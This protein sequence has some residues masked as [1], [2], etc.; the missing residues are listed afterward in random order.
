MDLNEL[1]Q[2]YK[3]DKISVR[4]LISRIK[5]SK[6][7]CDEVTKRTSFLDE[8][9]P[10][11]II[12]RLYYLVNDLTEVVKC[13]YCDNKA[14]WCKR[15]LKDGYKEVC[16]SRECR[17]KQLS[18]AHTGNTTISENRDAEFI[19]WQKTVTEINDDIVKEHIKY[20]KFIPLITNE[21]ILDY[22]N[23]RYEDSDSLEET[24]KRIEL[25]IEEKPICALPGCNRPVTFIGRQRALFTKF[26]C[27]EHSAQSEETR[28]RCRQTNLEHWGTENVYDSE[29]YKQL[30]ME[31]YGVPYHFLREDIISKRAA[32][33]LERYGTI[34]PNQCKEIM[35]K[36]R[37]TTFEHYGYHCVFDIPEIF[38]LSHSEETIEKI[39]NT[40]LERCGSISPWGSKEVREQIA[41]TNLERYG[42]ECIFDIPEV[43]AKAHSEEAK[44]KIRETNLKKYGYTSPLASPE[45]RDKIYESMKQNATFQ[46]SKKEDEVYDY[47]ISLGY[48]AER[49]YKTKEFPFTCDIYLPEYDLYIE[50]QGSHFHNT[51]SFTGCRED[52][53]VLKEY[54][55]KS[56]ELKKEKQIELSQYDNMIYVW[57]DLDVRKRVFAQEH[58]VRYLEIYKIESL[59][60]VKYQL[61]F[62]LN[63][64]NNDKIFNVKEKY[65]MREFEYY[66]T[67]QPVPTLVKGVGCRNL[68]V[69]HF[70]CNEFYKKEIEIYA[71]KPIERRKVIQNRCKE[72][73][74]KERELGPWEIMTGFKKSGIY[75][76]YSHF[77]P[78][79]TNWFVNKYNIK[80]VYDPC[81]GW[82]HHMLGMLN[83]DK[84]VYNE[85]NEKVVSNVQM[86]KDFFKIDNLEIHNEDAQYYVPDNV[87]AFFMCPPYYN[88][89]R[90][91]DKSFETLDEYKA[92]LNSIFRIWRVSAANIFGLI[93][94][95]DFVN[96][97]DEEFSESYE[98]VY[99]ESHFSRKNPKKNREMFYIF[100]K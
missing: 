11:D 45:V 54:A 20:D 89:E 57:S 27:P 21:I 15:G 97:I 96:L 23:N 3:K 58:N 44:Q 9:N 55:A 30:M 73:N 17:N 4:Q 70:Q 7:L 26:C 5:A 48:K 29:K 19:E 79:W 40:N 36:V 69:R 47:I 75:Y 68:I 78:K 74:K 53:E 51:Y 59:E 42:Y 77:N 38:E 82:G 31:K 71:T 93:I 25:G 88:V 98:V 39:H 13:K 6:E 94:R 62:L 95:E 60:E 28:D 12:E 83:C 86:M 41:K 90:Y 85:L 67:L 100:K 91:G 80:T 76:G 92:F 8:Y 56:E 66:K 2:S 34:Y 33:C 84:I 52:F 46:K 10:Y 16:S 64:I 43:Q 81:G 65:L 14:S 22:L 61:E 1:I 87:D 24:L 99:G 35:D 63:C 49:H 18:D 50:Y 72:L 32:T 37:Q